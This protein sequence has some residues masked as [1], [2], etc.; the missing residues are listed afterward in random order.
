MH[1]RI[2]VV[3]TG[4]LC[5]QAQG[6]MFGPKIRFFGTIFFLK[7]GVLLGKYFRKQT[8]GKKSVYMIG[9]DSKMSSFLTINTL[10]VHEL[11]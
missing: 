6:R 10:N 8:N 3:V 5:N 11:F 7:I 2:P 9:P 1:V 4:V